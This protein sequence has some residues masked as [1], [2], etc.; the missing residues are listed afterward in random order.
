MRYFLFTDMFQMIIGFGISTICCRSTIFGNMSFVGKT[1]MQLSS[2]YVFILF[3]NLTITVMTP[4]NTGICIFLAIKIIPCSMDYV[5]WAYW[6][7]SRNSTISSLLNNCV[8]KHNQHAPI[9][10]YDM[11][12]PNL[13]IILSIFW[14]YSFFLALC[15]M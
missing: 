2:I 15:I 3:W 7:A 1:L 13:F 11:E 12:R 14:I 8:L 10:S 9:S 5:W 4:F 6:C